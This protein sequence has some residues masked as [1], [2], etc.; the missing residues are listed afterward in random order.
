MLPSDNCGARLAQKGQEDP[1][2]P[3][4]VNSPSLF[5]PTHVR[6]GSKQEEMGECR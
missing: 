2:P 3:V 6:S 5:K 4:P 1:M